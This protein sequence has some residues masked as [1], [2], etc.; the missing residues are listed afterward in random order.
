[1]F[2]GLSFFMLSDL[3]LKIRSKIIG[4]KILF[5]EKVDSTNDEA[6]KL[7]LVDTAEGTVVVADSQRKGR[8]RLGR[9]WISHKAKGIYMSVMI[10]PY[11]NPAKLPFITYFASIAVARSIKGITGLDVKIKWPNDIMI[12]GKKVGGILTEAVES[13]AA[14][15]AVIVGIGINVNNTISSFPRSIR[16]TATS[17]KFEIGH[18]VDVMKL[19]KVIIEEFD[20]LY[21]SFLHKHFSDIIEEWFVNSQSMGEWVTIKTGKK[22]IEGLAESIGPSGELNIRTPSGKIKKVYSG[23]VVSSTEGYLRRRSSR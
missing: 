18:A 20:K 8:G 17:L 16:K 11:V 6:K 10:R 12:A 21:R 15:K 13:R 7:A 9:S 1:L 5:A 22:N 4:K 2:S 14:G 23:D 3:Q 19:L